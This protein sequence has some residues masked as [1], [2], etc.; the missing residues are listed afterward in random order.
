MSS[1]FLR[2]PSAMLLVLCMAL[3][4]FFAREKPITG[5]GLGV[6]CE[7]SVYYKKLLQGHFMDTKMPYRSQGD[8][9]K[10]G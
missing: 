10:K 7:D 6:V 3:A 8:I 9:I 4:S 1:S 5:I 2:L